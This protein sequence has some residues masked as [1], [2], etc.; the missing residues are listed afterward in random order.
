MNKTCWCILMWEDNRGWTFSPRKHYYELWTVFLKLK[1]LNDLFLT[2]TQLFNAQDINWYTGVLF[3]SCL[4]SHSDGTHSLQRI[5]WWTSDGMISS[6]LFWWRNKITLNGLRE[7]K[8]SANVHF[9]VNYSFN[10]IIIWI[11]NI[12]G[13]VK[14]ILKYFNISLELN[15]W[16]HKKLCAQFILIASEPVF[17]ICSSADKF[18]ICLISIASRSWQ[19]NMWQVWLD[20]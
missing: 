10:I 2:N 8:L 12:Y 19:M 5:H 9:W 13:M 16:P 11:I 1:H 7:S 20:T 14:F 4:D 6:N 15:N 17:N 18:G 3:I